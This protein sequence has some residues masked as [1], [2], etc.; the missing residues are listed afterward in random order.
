MTTYSTNSIYRRKFMRQLLLLI[1]IFCLPAA[2][3][4]GVHHDY[5][6][7]LLKLLLF[8]GCG[9]L[10]YFYEKILLGT[11]IL[12]TM[13]LAYGVVFLLMLYDMSLSVWL[14]TIPAFSFALLK[15]KVALYANL[16][17]GFLLVFGFWANT[18]VSGH[19][20]LWDECINNL[21]AYVMLSYACLVFHSIS[22]RYREQLAGIEAERRQLQATRT[23]SAGVAHLINNQMA[24]IVGYVSMLKEKDH[25][26]AVVLQRIQESAMKTS[27]HA[28]DLLAYAKKTVVDIQEQVHL[29]IWVEQ[30]MEYFIFPE[31]I[32][33]SIHYDAGLPDLSINTKQIKEHVLQ[34]II[35]NAV[36][37]NPKSMIEIRIQVAYVDEDPVLAR[38]DYIHLQVRDDGDGM[39]VEV[40]EQAFQP[41]YTTKFLGRGMGLAAAQGAVQRHGGDIKLESTPQQGTICHVWLPIKPIMA[42]SQDGRGELV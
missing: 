37:S 22:L 2:L 30:S 4:H 8:V 13:I 18:Q 10:L 31:H 32:G 5:E 33:V 34:H 27:Q 21:A 25:S 26:D 1:M 38:G 36:E 28:N 40:L 41:F 20:F 24:P 16:W 3:Y 19:D 17:G 11:V 23:L 9:I 39:D 42:C 7:L 29:G 15:K 14:L 6:V 12:L 35:Q